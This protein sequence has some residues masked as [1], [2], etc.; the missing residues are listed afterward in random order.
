MQDREGLI[1]RLRTDA[2]EDDGRPGLRA[3]DS[4]RGGLS[5]YAATWDG[6]MLRLYSNGEMAESRPR[7]G[8]LNVWSPELP[9]VIGAEGDGGHGWSGEVHL[10]AVYG[11]ALNA[12][13]LRR[14]YF[15]GGRQLSIG[16]APAANQAPD[17]DAGDERLTSLPSSVVRLR[18]KASDDGLPGGAL[19]LEWSQ[20]SGPAD[21]SFEATNLLNSAVGLAAPGGYV[22]ELAADDGQ[23]TLRDQVQVTVLPESYARLLDHATWGPTPEL[24]ERLREI[25]PDRFIEE[26]FAA[27]M[28]DFRQD[29]IGGLRPVQDRFFFHALYGEDQLRQRM[30]FALSK[31][32]VVSANAVGRRDQMVPYLRLLNEHAFGNYYDLL[33]EVTLS[34]TMGEYLDMVN[35]AAQGEEFPEPPNEN[36]AREL[37]QLLTIG[38]ELL[39]P[40]G[41]PQLGPDGEPLPS[42]TEDD[43]RSFT[44]ALTGWTYP[45]RPNGELRWANRDHYDG[46]MESLEEHHDS[47]PKTLLNGTV[48]PAGRTARQDLDDA[49][50]NLFEHP[51]M[52]PFIGKQLIQ[53]L[54]SS[55]PSPA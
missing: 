37:M 40:D 12:A 3:P 45:T 16:G 2:T 18:G 47:E 49:L 33:H 28:S 5:Q 20:L 24:I 6:A 36:Y 30:M 15:V 32:L 4:F 21:A 31:I 11:R 9:L 35:N 17:T 34:P 25:G 41:T 14:N 27:P 23:F 29:D 51:N 22:F 42:Y 7:A 38:T 55:N 48:L 39:N 53:Q 43:V 52:G 26:Q 10:I 1:A 13:E 50:R 8:D 44:R 46:R 54:V 19:H